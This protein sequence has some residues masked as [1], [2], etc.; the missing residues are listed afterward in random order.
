MLIISDLD[1]AQDFFRLADALRERRVP[2]VAVA[3]SGFQTCTEVGRH[4]PADYH[5]PPTTEL[6]P[7][8]P[9]T[10]WIAASYHPLYV[11]DGYAWLRQVV[12][13][14]RVGRSILLYSVSEADLARLAPTPPSG[15]HEPAV[16]CAERGRQEAA[17]AAAPGQP[18]GKQ[19][20]AATTD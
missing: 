8:H 20:P 5:F 15:P 11:V 2:Q 12:P 4:D 9:Q 6:L 1:L 10:G 19:L 3:L 17:S 13:V 18:A 7:D 16:T 14:A